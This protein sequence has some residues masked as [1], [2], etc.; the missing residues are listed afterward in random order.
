M[1][2]ILKNCSFK[3][4]VVSWKYQVERS[5]KEGEEMIFNTDYADGGGLHV[6]VCALMVSSDDLNLMT[7]DL[8]LEIF[9][10]AGSDFYVI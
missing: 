1:C 3:P 2:H 9:L 4:Q 5:K 10:L 6:T 8:R 7:D